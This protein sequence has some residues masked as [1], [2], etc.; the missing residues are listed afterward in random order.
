MEKPSFCVKK[1]QDALMSET[2]SSAAVA[3]MT[4]LDGVVGCVLWHGVDPCLERL[5]A[6][7]PVLSRDQLLR[8]AELEARREDFADRS[9]AGSEAAPP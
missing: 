8:V 7:E 1:S 6:L 5:P 4:G 3:L 9:D 2:N